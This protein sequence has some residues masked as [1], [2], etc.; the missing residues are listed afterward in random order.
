VTRVALPLALALAACREAAPAPE[1]SVVV[2][3]VADT[4]RIE[5]PL[6]ARQ[7]RGRG[8]LLEAQE[9][10]AGM[11]I[12]LAPGA[13]GDS[14][15]YP[16][17]V[18]APDSARRAGVAVRFFEQRAAHV[19]TLDSGTVTLSADDGGWAGTVT[20]SGL[21]MIG[22]TRVLVTATF[23]RV[24]APRDTVPCERAP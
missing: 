16:V 15:G 12:W 11:V 3:R 18:P 1:L 9:R 8:L 13:E 20:G 2:A 10:G 7:C 21:D 14:G 17:T 24:P 22:A 19:V 6:A 4:I 5:L 23:Q